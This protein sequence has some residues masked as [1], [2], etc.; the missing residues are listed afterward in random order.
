[1]AA[2][3]P[4]VFDAAAYLAL[5]PDVAAAGMDALAHYLTHGRAEGRWPHRPE[6]PG[7]EPDLWRG[8]ADQAAPALEALM[9][10]PSGHE[11][12]FAAWALARWHAAEGRTEEAARLLRAH[13]AEAE[14]PFAVPHPGP[15]LLAVSVLP[16]AEARAALAAAVARHPGL[17]D[18]R[19]AAANL[20]GR[21]EAALAALNAVWAQAGLARMRLAR[22]PGP[23]FDRLEPALSLAALLPRR[24]PGGARVSVI[25]PARNAAATLPAALSGLLRQDWRDLEILVVDDAS[26]D[27]TLAVA[28]SFAA[29][30]GR[31][32]AIRLE[33]SLGAYVARNAGLA[34]ATGAFVTVQDADDWPHPA[35]IA[36]QVAPL[37]ADPALKATVSHWVRATPALAFGLWRAEAAWVH[38]NVSSL[39]LR[40]ELRGSLGFWDRVR[41]G[42]DTEYYYRLQRAFGPACIAEVLPGVPLALGRIQPGSL[43]QRPETHAR[44]QFAGPRHDYHL[45]ATL[46]HRRAAAPADLF[47]PERPARRPFDIP[48]V[49]GVGDPDPV[50]LPEDIVRRS[51]LFDAGWYRAVYPDVR[52]A[53]VCP[54]HQYVVSG[55]AEARDPGPAFST[56]AYRL[57]VDCG[58]ENPLVHWETRGRA[59]GLPAL[60][61]FPGALAGAEG[62]VRLIFGHR[63]ETALAG[64]ERSLVGM[65]EAA[66]AA[67]DVPVAVLPAAHNPGYIAE[68]AARAA[69]V[70]VLPYLWR[71]RGRA[72]HP[73]TI[74]LMQGLIRQYRPAAVHANTLVLDA[75]LIAARAEG[76]AA[77][78]HVRELPAEDPD[79]CAALGETPEEVRAWLLAAAD[80]FVANS[81]AVAAW[82]GAPDR[83]RIEPVHVDP[84]LF[85]LP[86]AP[87]DPPRVALVSS[88]LAKKGLKDVLAVARAVAAQG[89]AARFL[90]IGPQ[91]HDLLA[92]G[93]LPPGVEAPGPAPDPVAAMA[94]ADIVLSLSHFAE[95]FGR[96]VL[97]A[98][99]AGRPV[100]AYARGTPA[101]MVADGATGFL[102][103]PDDPAAAAAAVARLLAD[104]ALMARQSAAARAR[105]A[106]LQAAALAAQG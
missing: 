71:R 1:M 55:A 78:V 84:A 80:R 47:L 63:A 24:P 46:W 101:E 37:L 92:L 72:P 16:A 73:R 10:G 6:G 18:L 88:N 23:A 45:A 69:A 27:D 30:D 2:A 42:A 9:R 77:V 7:I 49:L 83:T 13:L 85:G 86:F 4:A 29:R 95:S 103:P 70:H 54:A 62:P 14:A 99:A 34:A 40:A 100:V 82:I 106:A 56:T 79:L 104:P 31:V 74:A 52:R 59:A 58:A 3:A 93:P 26:E 8:F 33:Q 61:V 102:V 67:G 89:L 11:R 51:A 28:Q 97:E 50:L 76:V 57:A 48:P 39:M 21:A 65:L 36:R 94:G 91:T 41:A 53:E 25:V 87:A 81:A 75:P 32:R 22:G 15:A 66:R 98:M 20:D 17:P 44:T 43:T 105:A 5:N 64:A 90:L 19:L 12:A 35:K 96:T 38:R 60:P 68:L